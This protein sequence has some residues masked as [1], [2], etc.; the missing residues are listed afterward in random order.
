MAALQPSGDVWG[1]LIAASPHKAR[2]FGAGDPHILFVGGEKSG[3]STLQL[4]FAGRS[5]EAP[6][7]LALN[8]QSLTVKMNN[9]L[10]T[11]HLWELGG[12]LQL[13]SILDTIVTSDTQ[14]GFVVFVCV[15]LMS[16]SSIVDGVE[17]MD[18]VTAR[19][20]E[21]RTA[22]FFVGTHYDLFEGRDAKEKEEIVR[23]LRAVAAQQRAGI[24][25]TA[26]NR[27]ALVTRFR[28]V[29]M[30][31]ALGNGKLRE[32]A[33]EAAEP[34]VV[35][36]GDDD[37]ERTNSGAVAAMMNRAREEAA[38]E[39]ERADAEAKNTAEEYPEEEIDALRAAR[40]QELKER[41]EAQAAA[42]VTPR[43]K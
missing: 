23:G 30:C 40:R 14:R 4:M 24:V 21:N 2:H 25:F 27:E 22:V 10:I 18:H 9:R 28:K 1:G 34:V 19:F 13:E 12:G 38:G 36:P 29:V 7:T 5:D 31:V 37:D 16:P 26:R 6:A 32:R 41:R 42:P 11:L 17:W 15:N 43:K 3:K 33:V 8:Y 20:G 35:G 39:G